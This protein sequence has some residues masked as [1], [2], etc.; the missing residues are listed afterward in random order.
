[1]KFYVAGRF[2]DLE[3]RLNIQDM[4]KVLEE[5][6]HTCTFNWTSGSETKPYENN[7]ELTA[8]YAIKA[9]EGVRECELFI[10]V[11][12]HGGTGMYVEY[13]IALA[14]HLRTGMP[15]LYLTGS[16]N[17]CSMFNYHP[18]LIWKNSLQEILADIEK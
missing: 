5:K 6:G 13:G 2:S 7:P 16:H 12:H 18:K 14:E 4:I 3:S 1:M 15:K 8:E 17:N 11:S 9:A 10:L